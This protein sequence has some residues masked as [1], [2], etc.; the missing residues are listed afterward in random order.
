MAKR[1]LSKSL[2]S[3]FVLLLACLL[4]T[5]LAFLSPSRANTII[6]EKL[7]PPYDIHPKVKKILFINEDEFDFTKD[8]LY[9]R[10]LE[11]AESLNHLDSIQYIS[12][13]QMRQAIKNSD[14]DTFAKLVERVDKMPR[15]R[16]VLQAQ[17]WSEKIRYYKLDRDVNYLKN[18]LPLQDNIIA[19][20]QQLGVKNGY[21]IETVNYAEYL[22]LIGDL[23]K[24][25]QKLESIETQVERSREVRIK[26]VFYSE[27]GLNAYYQKNIEESITYLNLGLQAAKTVENNSRVIAVFY[28][29]LAM[30]FSE[31][32][33][34]DIAID[35]FKKAHE[36]IISLEEENKLWISK[37]LNNIAIVLQ[38]DGK[39]NEALEYHQ[40]SLAIKNQIGD[41][42]G[43]GISYS[44]IADVFLELNRLDE[45]KENFK[46]AL[47]IFKQY[48]F[49]AGIVNAS[50]G[51]A[52]A[53]MADEKTF[54]QALEHLQ[55]A[56][57]LSSSMNDRVE[58]LESYELTAK[59]YEQSGDYK[60]A[61]K[62]YKQYIDLF[63]QVKKL[64]SQKLL[65]KMQA[66]YENDKQKLKIDK[67]Q[68][69]NVEQEKAIEQYQ[70]I[71]NILLVVLTILLVFG[72]AVLTHSKK[73]DK[74]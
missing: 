5:S 62:L 47:V 74:E 55:A 16:S 24:A 73:S 15:T 3:E 36:L 7:L 17:L 13:L 21:L 46:S 25:R 19:L 56:I 35:Y 65:Q 23:L 26:E 39:H 54:E 18:N 34:N 28:S 40:K 44:S 22:R 68:R 58:L 31:I 72:V 71:R 60:N 10:A 64:E 67:L 11:V 8:D 43:I 63:Q 41:K 9:G 2:L 45:S 49:N 38:R 32:E 70:F 4:T 29:H 30:G 6:D 51:L 33:R 20:Y 53:L 37:S 52:K 12:L 50:L 42:L 61:T 48:G 1:G 59:W 66:L 14:R 27:M 69:S 57:D